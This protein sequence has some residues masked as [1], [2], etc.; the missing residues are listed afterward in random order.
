MSY[1]NQYIAKSKW[2][3]FISLYTTQHIG[4]GFMLV[5]LVGILRERGADLADL[6]I[7]YLIGVP[8]I[9]KFIWAP[10]I[11]HFSFL[12]KWGHYRGWLLIL[13]ALMIFS[14]LTIS[15]L[16]IDKQLDWVVLM[17]VIFA[18]F[19]ASQDV[20][21]DALSSIEF[22]QKQRGLINGIQ[23]SGGLLGNVIGGGLILILYPKI[24]WKGS[25]FLMAA[26]TSISW[27]QLLFFCESNIPKKEIF[28][29]LESLK[30]FCFFWRGKFL[31]L[32]FIF[33]SA[34][35]YSL[36]YSILTPIM[37]DAGKS[38]ANV[39]MTMN[40]FGMAVGVFMGLLAGWLIQKIGR[41]NALISFCFF[42]IVSFVAILP[43]AY[44]QDDFMLYMSCAVYFIAYPLLASIT[45]TFMMDYAAQGST[46]GT[47]YT[48]QFTVSTFTGILMGGV[49]LQI[50]H[51]FDYIGVL[52]V[53]VVFSIISFILAIIYS[54]QIS[55]CIIFSG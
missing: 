32:L 46:P 5:A 51:Y 45:S 53:A 54:K 17:G 39:G 24:G 3:L 33:F 50:A 34:I 15:Q 2:L 36:I 38:L 12:K 23:M 26:V 41:K 55:K 14:L 29:V 16:S 28:S 31:W 25:F 48:L 19:S 4:I 18:T 11:D 43:V 40:V 8:W 1:K 13:Q 37:L 7:V 6:S 35:G 44:I 20:A 30:K 10:I 22:N 47:D 52:A 49:A 21:T 42:Q 27:F 9:L